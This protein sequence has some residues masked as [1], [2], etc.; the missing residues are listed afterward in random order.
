MIK[1][2]GNQNAHKIIIL[3]KNNHSSD[4]VKKL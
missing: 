4:E 2:V 1:S 3:L